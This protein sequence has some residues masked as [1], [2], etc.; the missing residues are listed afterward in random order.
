MSR[1]ELVCKFRSYLWKHQRVIA[2]GYSLTLICGLVACLTISRYS[3]PAFDIGAVMAVRSL[4]FEQTFDEVNIAEKELAEGDLET[5]AIRLQRFIERHS[6]IQPTTL[7]AA[8]VG[9]A[10][11]LLVETQIQRGRLGKAEKSAALWAKMLP[12]DYRAWYVLGKVRKA[13]GDSSG[14]ADAMGEAFKLTLC[15]A[16]ITDRYLGLLADL[17]QY[18][19]II[20]VAHQYTNAE[21]MSRPT[22]EVFVGEGRSAL[23]RKVMGMVDLPVG[24][25]RYY[26]R[27]DTKL[28]RGEDVIEIPPELF[29]GSSGIETLY[30]MLKVRN[31]FEDLE[32]VSLKFRGQD[33]NWLESDEPNYSMGTLHRRHSGSSAHYELKTRVAMENVMGCEIRLFSPVYQLSNESVRIIR[34]AEANLE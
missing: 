2:V 30:I 16:E 22:V 7:Y 21:K 12:R 6:D 17:N 24:H 19:R 27:Y 4:A 3:P 26:Y 1:N 34:R 8:S 18:E 23:M 15:I 32:I 31:V 28:E 20:W 11:E 29:E 25:G 13:G 14:A 10:C 5:A 33:G 9:R